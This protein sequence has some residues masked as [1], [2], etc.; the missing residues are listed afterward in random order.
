M[1]FRTSRCVSGAGRPPGRGKNAAFEVRTNFIGTTTLIDEL[2]QTS[3]DLSF[4]T[5]MLLLTL[6][7]GNLWTALN[8]HLHY[9]GIERPNLHWQQVWRY[10]KARV[11]VL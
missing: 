9:Y 4:T 6:G 1:I 11:F 8:P 10:V 5:T 3:V 7:L 2:S